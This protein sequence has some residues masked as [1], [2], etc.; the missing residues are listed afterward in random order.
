MGEERSG[1]FSLGHTLLSV[2]LSFLLHVIYIGLG[3]SLNFQIVGTFGNSLAAFRFD[4]LFHY[5]NELQ[6]SNA[7]NL[8]NGYYSYLM[9]VVQPRMQKMNEQRKKGGDLTYPYFIP[10]WMPNGIQT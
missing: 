4:S 3:N 6:D 7:V 5:G 8:V 10:R 9:H 1:T 2:S